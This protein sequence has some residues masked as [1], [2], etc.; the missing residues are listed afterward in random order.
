M[1]NSGKGYYKKL[2]RERDYSTLFET[3]HNKS[4][5]KRCFI[6]GNGSSLTVRDLELLKEED[7]IG[8]N[9]IHRIF[10]HT[11]WRPKYYVLMDRYSKTT[12]EEIEK[13]DCE[14]VFLG[15]YYWRHNR[16]L[17]NDAICLKQKFLFSDK[18]YEFSDDISKCIYVGPT[19][20]FASMQI[21]SYLGY[22]EMV[23]VGFDHLY[24][25]IFDKKGRVVKVDTGRNNHFFADERPDDI[26]ANV[27]G[28]T[29][30]YEAAKLYCDNHGIRIM[31]ATRG[32]CLDVFDR[33]QLEQVIKR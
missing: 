10:E 28:M 14:K 31:N 27:H 3:L 16:V 25:N 11:L 23:L 5:G 30:A 20:S 24:N 12:P 33:V 21:A 4:Y 26:I 8:A 18:K 6:I 7:C 13:I 15:D 2:Y 32:G 19:V 29:L 17:R 22:K 1:Y 9:E